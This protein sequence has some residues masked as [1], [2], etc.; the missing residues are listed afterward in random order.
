MNRAAVGSKKNLSGQVKEWHVKHLTRGIP[1]RKILK[2]TSF[3][4]SSGSFSNQL[5]GER[6][7]T[8][9]VLPEMWILA[10]LVQ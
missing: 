7:R 5:D 4:I 2:I 9:L 3:K 1:A 8:T 6:G 10:G